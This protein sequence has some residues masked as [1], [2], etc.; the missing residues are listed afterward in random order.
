MAADD[1]DARLLAA[2]AAGDRTAL[3][4]LY[5]EAAAMSA[6]DRS[7]FFLVHA[8]VFALDAGLAQA[9]DYHARLKAEGRE[10]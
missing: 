10:E 2:H 1:L 3:A 8:Y 9:A 7:A 6:G 4:G 5:A